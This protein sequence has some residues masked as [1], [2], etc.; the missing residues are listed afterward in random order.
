MRDEVLAGDRDA[1]VLPGLPDLLE[2]R[3]EP[4][5]DDRLEGGAGELLVRDPGD[6]GRVHRGG[7]RDELG[8]GG[9]AIRRRRRGSVALSGPRRRC[10]SAAAVLAL[11]PSAMSV[12]I[13]VTRATA[14]SS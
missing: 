8:G 3:H 6:L 13:R 1:P 5:V 9:R 12:A 10:T 11:Q 2:R 4:V 7:G 14:S